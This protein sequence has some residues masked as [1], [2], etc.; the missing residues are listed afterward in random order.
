MAPG[1]LL[2]RRVVNCVLARERVYL[3]LH[4]EV[5]EIARGSVVGHMA[6]EIHSPKQR[7][8]VRRGGV[9]EGD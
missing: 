2:V 5:E 7:V 4:Q 6:I 9:R 8:G 3:A 1:H